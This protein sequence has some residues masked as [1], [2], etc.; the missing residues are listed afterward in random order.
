MRFAAVFAMFVAVVVLLGGPT[1]A[2]PVG[3][4]TATPGAGGAVAGYAWPTSGVREVVRQFARPAA[5]WAAGHRGADLALAA[6]EPVLAAGS[7]VVVFA[8]WVVDRG[9]V[10]IQHDDGLR[11]TY[12]PV[13]AAVSPGDRVMG[14]EA[15]GVLASGDHCQV[16]CLHF[17][18][19]R[20]DGTYLD[21]ML[22]L[23]VVPQIRLLPAG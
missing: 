7:G 1:M 22:L 4:A 10:S 18:V 2:H 3:E 8:G 6:G 13:T 21:P 11:T 9:V 16:S 12:E 20:G 15:V 19:R 17:G 5:P 14:G 23:G